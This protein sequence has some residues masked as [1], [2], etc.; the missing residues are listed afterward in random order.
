MT[1][2]TKALEHWKAITGTVTGTVATVVVIGQ[3]YSWPQSAE[4]AKE[5]HNAIRAEIKLASA[6]H[7][8]LALRRAL[9]AELERVKLNLTLLTKLAA[10]RPL[11]TEEAAELDYYKTRRAQI[12]DQLRRL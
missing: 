4:A 2:K 8:Q 6:E 5:E 3:V 1:V 9:E 7:E 10:I 11:T 12:I